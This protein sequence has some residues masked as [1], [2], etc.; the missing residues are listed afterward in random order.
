MMVGYGWTCENRISEI[1]IK[2]MNTKGINT[3][4]PPHATIHTS[5]RRRESFSVR[6][7]LWGTTLNGMRFIVAKAPVQ[8]R[9]QRAPQRT[10]TAKKQPKKQRYHAE[11]FNNHQL[12]GGWSLGG[13]MCPVGGRQTRPS[14]EWRSARA[15]VELVVRAMCR[16]CAMP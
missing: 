13:V 3:T 5:M 9:M 8:S 11:R 10:A 16:N 15:V 7:A 4:Q 6:S 2:I 1:R 12:H 14:T